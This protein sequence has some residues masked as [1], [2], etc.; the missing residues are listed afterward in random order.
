MGNFLVKD[1]LV[2]SC[3]FDLIKRGRI[4]RPM[5]HGQDILELMPSCAQKIALYTPWWNAAGNLEEVGRFMYP[6]SHFIG[7]YD[8]LVLINNYNIRF[9]W[10]NSA[11][12]RYVSIFYFYLL[13]L[14]L[15]PGSIEVSGVR[16]WID[17]LDLSSLW[18]LDRYLR[19]IL[20]ND[21]I[22][23]T[24]EL[25]QWSKED[26]QRFYF[27]NK[28]LKFACLSVKLAM[29]YVFGCLRYSAKEK[30][31]DYEAVGVHE[32]IEFVVEEGNFTRILLGFYEEEFFLNSPKEDMMHEFSFKA[33]SLAR[34]YD[35]LSN[36]WRRSRDWDLGFRYLYEFRDELHIRYRRI[37]S[38]YIESYT[39]AFL[40]DWF[41]F[42]R[43]LSEALAP[44]SDS[45][46]Y[47][48][49]ENWR[50][51]D[52]RFLFLLKEY[53]E[54]L[55]VN[56]VKKLNSDIWDVF[57]ESDFGSDSVE[58]GL[59]KA[60][61][62][63]LLVVGFA[64][65][66][67]K[68]LKMNTSSWLIEFFQ[69]MLI[70]KFSDK[71]NFSFLEELFLCST[72]FTT[73]ELQILFTKFDK[74]LLET[75]SFKENIEESNF[76]F[77]NDPFF[78]N[79]FEPFLKGTVLQS[80]PVRKDSF[81]R[82]R[83]ELLRKDFINRTRATSF[84]S[85]LV[86]GE[87][88]F[89]RFVKTLSRNL[90]GNYKWSLVDL[91]IKFSLFR[92]SLF[93]QFVDVFE[94]FSGQILM[95]T[96]DVS[97]Y[98]NVFGRQ[99]S[100]FGST[101]AFQEDSYD[102]GRVHD[103]IFGFTE[104][105]DGDSIEVKEE[106][107]VYNSLTDDQRKDYMF[108]SE[109][110]PAA[111]D[112]NGKLVRKIT[113][114]SDVVSNAFDDYNSE[115]ET[116]THVFTHDK[117]GLFSED[118]L[119]GF[120]WYFPRKE[121]FV[122][123]DYK[124]SRGFLR[125]NKSSRRGF[126]RALQYKI[127]GVVFSE[128]VLYSILLDPYPK[129]KLILTGR[130]KFDLYMVFEPRMLFFMLLLPFLFFGEWRVC[131]EKWVE[132]PLPTRKDIFWWSLV[133]LGFIFIFFPQFCIL[134]TFFGV[135]FLWNY[136]GGVFRKLLL[137]PWSYLFEGI[138]RVGHPG[139]G[140]A[141]YR[142]D[143][144]VFWLLFKL[145]WFYLFLKF[146]V[147]PYAYEFGLFIDRLAYGFILNGLSPL[148]LLCCFFGIIVVLFV[149]LFWR[150]WRNVW[151]GLFGFFVVIAYVSNIAHFYE[152]K[153]KW[154]SPYNQNQAW[155]LGTY[156]GEA[157]P[158]VWLPKPP[159]RKRVG[160]D[161]EFLEKVL[162]IDDSGRKVIKES[163]SSNKP[164]NA[165]RR[166]QTW[167][168]M[169]KAASFRWFPVKPIGYPLA[170]AMARTKL[171]T[172]Y[173][174]TYRRLAITHPNAEEDRFYRAGKSSVPL[175]FLYIQWHYPPRCPVVR[176]I[177][178]IPQVTAFLNYIPQAANF[179]FV[180]ISNR[181]W[182]ELTDRQLYRGAISMPHRWGEWLD[183]LYFGMPGKTPAKSPD[184]VKERGVGNANLFHCSYFS[185]FRGLF[186]EYPFVVCDIGLKSV[187]DYRTD[188]SLIQWGYRSCI[189]NLQDLKIT[190]GVANKRQLIFDHYGYF[191]PNKKL[192]DELD[193]TMENWR[194]PNI[195]HKE[196]IRLYPL[197]YYANFQHC[198]HVYMCYLF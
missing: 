156:F 20:Q 36:D 163:T 89:P 119:W 96:G 197:E 144:E 162:K 11:Y 196:I 188:S 104:L 111:L 165:V 69:K 31:L 87:K 61:S 184:P 4:V 83:Q 48:C 84:G 51:S 70:K 190:L 81:R 170:D 127:R 195:Y 77:Y 115:E 177:V 35:N 19:F 22:S 99:R 140:S 139:G 55:R 39:A 168:E 110:E 42:L 124:R 114:V 37:L 25:S 154:F 28:N 100:Q 2:H 23:R 186:Y 5:R 161:D 137:Y 130:N 181:N 73:S 53:T 155:R 157:R 60:R 80:I 191:V 79:L 41:D 88:Y 6:S 121:E 159:R 32:T 105:I 172:F 182:T 17:S 15:R 9:Q 65:F 29:L 33:P 66:F 187:L 46:D 158:F 193:Y 86:F 63:W 189:I 134:L 56:L 26:F 143:S 153:S 128:F 72:V 91:M 16:A 14:N 135:W 118:R 179:T 146:I 10:G 97:P 7:L 132:V 30:F 122:L 180:P 152:T 50:L 13:D 150:N 149:G 169:I 167:R 107:K 92:D 75:S 120:Q 113:F 178:P 62:D 112:D 126:M 40:G 3:L 18:S 194:Y 58:T 176:K 108:F 145:L 198:S 45:V 125:D 44:N 85:L 166:A 117:S 64:G 164:S 116:F 74:Q 67:S 106:R 8:N 95:S 103:D 174:D 123:W 59:L 183:T 90:V 43:Q 151:A 12:F 148:F 24:F 21:E 160:F 142:I 71:F 82:Y 27:P 1:K 133:S 173:A 93:V 129:W 175:E 102:E 147:A 78:D 171:T 138:K 109:Y 94:W 136:T 68:E 141:Q 54:E 192:E 47:K 49:I 131:F 57:V 52:L 76:L 98:S 38:E 101:T 185:F 34:R